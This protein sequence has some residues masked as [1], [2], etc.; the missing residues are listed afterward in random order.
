MR[1]LYRVWL[2]NS[3]EGPYYVVAETT[4]AAVRAVIHDMN[5]KDYGFLKDRMLKRIDVVATENEFTSIPRLYL[6]SE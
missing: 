6:V 1:H 3:I 5:T 2:R 4:D